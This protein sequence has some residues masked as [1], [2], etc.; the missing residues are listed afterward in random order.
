MGGRPHFA[1]IAAGVWEKL[2]VR[3]SIV[4]GTRRAD[5]F[6][7]FGRGSLMCFPPTALFGESSMHIGEDTMIGPHCAIT[8]GMVPGQDLFADRMLTIGDR[9]VIGRG[10]SI[11]AHL[12][13]TIG[14][15]VFFAPNVFVTDQNHGND[16]SGTP[17]GRQTQPEKPV[18]IGARSWLAT[19]VVVTPGV[20]IGEEVSIGANSV[21]TQDL[22]DGCVAVGAPARV[23]G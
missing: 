19:G 20:T 13:I 17:I 15:D 4:A 22:P 11:A 5:R 1:D 2:T 14:D 10:S 23:V 8:V 12:S 7:Q 3:A 18:V 9:C 6:G 21:V 16:G